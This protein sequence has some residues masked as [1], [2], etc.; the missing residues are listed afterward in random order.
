[1][2]YIG[3][4]EA[5]FLV[6]T[7]SLPGVITINGG[8][9][10]SSGGFPGTVNTSPD[11]SISHFTAG[12]DEL[13]ATATDAF[14]GAGLT[15]DAAIIEFTVNTTGTDVNGISFDIVF[16][17]DEFPEFSNT[18]FVDIASIYVNGNNV[19]LFNDNPET[20]LSIINE[21]LLT[22]NFNDNTSGS[23]PIEW[24][25]FSNVLTVRAGLNT[26]SN[27][28]R[29][30]IAD[31]GDS[32]YDSALY[33]GDIEPLVNG[34]VGGGVLTKID[35]NA[36]D[37]V[38]MASVNN[39][40]INL[41]GGMDVVVGTPETLNN[42]IIT[43]FG[44]NDSISISGAQFT[45]ENIIV[46]FGSAILNIDTDGN[47]I[48]DTVITLEGN[49]ENS[50]FST[51]NTNGGTIINV[52]SS[53]S[54]NGAIQQSGTNQNDQ[55]VATPGA[56]SWDG[57]AG[58]DTVIISGSRDG[59]AVSLNG[60]SASISGD[61]IGDDLFINVERLQ[62]S[63]GVMALDTDGIAGQVYRMYQ[64]TFNRTPDTPGLKHNVTLV[65]NGLSIRDL[66][67]AFA[68][69]PEFQ[70]LFGTSTSNEAFINAMY[71]NVLGRGPDQAGFDGWNA[72]LESGEQDRG[73]ILFGFSES[74]ENIALVASA[75][76]NGIWLG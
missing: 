71:Q 64:A 27:T 22:G 29:I 69:S 61:L 48:S 41:I 49:F 63:D 74:P 45:S 54:N 3:S 4:G 5:A 37:D 36:G 1:V 21:N 19:A 68:G 44:S 70:E 34:G 13:S 24:D 18:S 28:I 76:E 25:G 15:Q 9:L 66:A 72:L 8:I 20:P 6:D 40:E 7:F 67:D 53:I 52:D 51:I 56:D 47:N 38:I 39:D 58:L 50:N 55:F 2:N 65:D 11:F 73:D 75:I 60:V 33:V 59:V 23:F 12:D 43:G 30:A 32:I 62:F 35:G 42:D 14:S 17:S 16:G 46:T 31:T 26:G 10:L 57:L